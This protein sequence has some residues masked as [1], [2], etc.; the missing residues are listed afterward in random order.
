MGKMRA[1]KTRRT[2]D[3]VSI[4]FPV[5]EGR[6][7]DGDRWKFT[8]REP[9]PEAALR[10]PR[11][12]YHDAASARWT[13]QNPVEFA[14]GGREPLPIH[15]PGAGGGRRAGT[16]PVVRRGPSPIETATATTPGR[17]GMRVD[18]THL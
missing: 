1:G 8:A 17:A 10:Y 13:S 14:A 18:F 6:P 12:R 15:R 9:D 16:I 7:A 4:P 11:A 5:S 3:L 2:D